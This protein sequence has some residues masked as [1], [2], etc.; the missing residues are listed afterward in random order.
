MN[1]TG[2][3][4]VVLAAA[5]D[6][7]GGSNGPD[8]AV[9]APPP[10]VVALD[11]CP[12]VVAATVMDSPTMFIP[13][14]TTIPAREVVKFVITAEHLVLPNSLVTTDPALTVRRGETKCFRFNTPGTYGFLCGVH[15]FTG[16]ITVQ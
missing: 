6:I 14:S 10:P 2:L 13:K 8:A 11:S 1:R 3:A 12:A 16:T 9:D 15:S 4:I 5:C 7:G